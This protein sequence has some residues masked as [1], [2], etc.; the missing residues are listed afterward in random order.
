MSSNGI[1]DLD[2]NLVTAGFL[3]G[4]GSLSVGITNHTNPIALHKIATNE[5][6]GADAFIVDS[7]EATAG[8]QASGVTFLSGAGSVGFQASGDVYAELAVFPDPTTSDFTSALGPMADTK[9][10]LPLDG[11]LSVVMLRWGADAKASGT[12]SIA[13]GAGAGSIDFSAGVTGSLFFA[14]LQ[15][16]PRTTPTDD[17]LGGVVKSWK[18]PVHVHSANDLAPRT[19]ILS[20]VGGSLTAS[21]SATFGHEFNWMRQVTI[22]GAGGN[23]SALSG[24]IGLKLQLGLKASFD[25]TMQGKYAVVVSRESDL[26]VIRVRIYKLKLNGFDFGFSASAAA[27]PS[28]PLPDDFNDLITAA[29]GTHA[30][31][32]LNELEDPNTIN[33]WITKFGTQYVGDLFQKFTGLDLTAAIAKVQGFAN[34]WQAVPSSA[35]SLFAKL[36]EKGI[37]DLSDIENAAKLIA[38]SDQ[39]GLRTFLESKINDLNLPLLASPLGQYLEG[40]AEGG[41]LTL[42]QDIPSSVQQE[43]QKT[44]DFLDGD[45]VEKLLNQ[46]VTEVNSR[47]GLNAILADIQ[48]DPATVLDKLLFSKLEAFLGRVPVLQDI[49]KLQSTIKTLQGKVGALYEKTVAALKSTYTAQLNATYQQTT[50]DTAL[51]DASFDFGNAGNAPGVRKALQQLL[52]GRLDDFL[53]QPRAGVTLASGALTHEVQRHSHVDLTLPFVKVEGDWISDA[54][55]SFNAVDENGGRLTTY[56]L[57]AVGTAERKTTLTS[58]WKGRNWRSSTIALTAQISS[59]L[60]AGGAVHVFAKS[61]TEQSRLATSRSSIRMEVENMTLKDLDIG[62]KPFATQFLRRAFADS[63]AFDRWAS[64]GGLLTS[65]ANTLVSLDVTLPGAVPLAWLSNTVTNKGGQVYKSLSLTL[66]F[67]LKRYLRD[68][69]FRDVNRYKTLAT[70]YLVLLYA[71]IPPENSINVNGA[72]STDGGGVYWNTTDINAVKGMA[73]LARQ[74]NSPQGF[75]GQLQAARSRLLAAGQTDL[76]KFYDSS[77]GVDGIFNQAMTDTNVNLLKNSLL[78]LERGVI[79]DA[80]TAALSAASYNALAAGN[81][82]A[83]ALKALADFGDNITEAFNHDLSSIFVEDNDAL[84]RLS[85]LIFAQAA[86]VFDP[87]ISATN[88]DSTLSVIELKPGAAMP[89]DFPNF[90]PVAADILLSLNAA[91]FGL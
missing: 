32:I 11:G 72:L 3:D 57:N 60:P 22:Q 19:H 28:V 58:L 62:I 43:A 45:S 24:D 38:G 66:Q 69:Y 33:S 53:T 39:D 20:E 90:T 82:P 75:A 63:A 18:L 42:L 50:T 80:C 61:A 51:I 83:E 5:P 81:K 64:T 31:Q 44:V 87:T 10:G 67:L 34:L 68:Y 65:P 54:T 1:Y 70:A 85:P 17:A 9:F 88:Y 91:S 21:I 41:G 76:A 25:L 4:K 16:V 27:T 13:L 84:Q 35:A 48:G 47:L 30:L 26:P 36:A 6:L 56:Q 7:V 71:A 2:K 49:Q 14:V 46:I 73:N 77:N 29:L 79:L 86:S 37:P 89:T 40:L 8:V 12:G 15:Q 74:S 52:A 55:T 78:A 23:Q 59:K